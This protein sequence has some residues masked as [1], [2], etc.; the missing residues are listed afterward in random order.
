VSALESFDRA[1]SQ[2]NDSKDSWY[3]LGVIFVR[4]LAAE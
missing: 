2:P 4:Q 1:L 3:D